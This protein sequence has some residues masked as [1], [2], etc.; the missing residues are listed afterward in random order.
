MPDFPAKAV[1]DQAAQ[2]LFIDGVEFPWPMVSPPVL[3]NRPD[4][5]DCTV[6]LTISVDAIEV[7][8]I[9]ERSEAE[10]QAELHVQVA[11]QKL[12]QATEGG[13]PVEIYAARARL[14]IAKDLTKSHG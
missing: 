10:C 13:D 4:T 5:G 1:L 8:P 14:A 11:V 7:L 12:T 3:A 2:K 6:T 9:P